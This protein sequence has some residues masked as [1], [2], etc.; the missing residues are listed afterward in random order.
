M[1]DTNVCVTNIS[2]LSQPLIAY[3]VQHCTLAVDSNISAHLFLHVGEASE[4]GRG[5]PCPPLQSRGNER[6][7][8]VLPAHHHSPPQL[9]ANLGETITDHH[10]VIFHVYQYRQLLNI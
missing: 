5:P 8:R 3:I 7:D 1:K 6:V 2:T 10:I 9:P 4:S